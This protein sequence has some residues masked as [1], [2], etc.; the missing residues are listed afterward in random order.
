[1]VAR[2]LL[3]PEPMTRKNSGKRS[4]AEIRR[5]YQSPADFR[6]FADQLSYLGEQLRTLASAAEE[7]GH[8]RLYVDGVKK[9]PNGMAEVASYVRNVNKALI[10]AQGP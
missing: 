3:L 9:F 10:D 6:A 1:M 5:E 7:G 8:K 2:G 4:A